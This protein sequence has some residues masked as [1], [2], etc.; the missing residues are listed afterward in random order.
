M[1]HQL[2][3]SL[4]ILIV[5]ALGYWQGSKER[6]SVQ[7]SAKVENEVKNAIHQR[8]DALRRGDVKD[9]TGKVSH[10]ILRTGSGDLIA[11]KVK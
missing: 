8:L 7:R 6:S 11:M 2:F 9:E 10:F 3:F 5:P 4:S 1:K